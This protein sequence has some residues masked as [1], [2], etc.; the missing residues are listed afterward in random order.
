MVTSGPLRSTIVSHGSL[1]TVAPP[2]S[3][4]RAVSR[5]RP[6]DRLAVFWRRRS[7]RAQLPAAHV[8]VERS[9]RPSLPPTCTM[10]SPVIVTP[11][12]WRPAASSSGLPV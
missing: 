2:W 10:S 7:D 9:S 6:S 12:R 8:Q 1:A 5:W 3:A 4:A 11:E